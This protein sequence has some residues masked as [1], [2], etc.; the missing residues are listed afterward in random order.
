MNADQNEE[1]QEQF[2]DDERLPL[3]TP[4]LTKTV[5]GIN[6]QREADALIAALRKEPANVP[7]HQQQD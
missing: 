7:N 5:E 6:L 1:Q 4:R 3:P 2:D